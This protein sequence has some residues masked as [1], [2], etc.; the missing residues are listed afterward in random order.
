MNYRNAKRLENGWIDCEI[1][2]D[3]F[4]WIPFTCDPND[5]EP[6]FDVAA[7]HATM[8]ADP[9]TADYVP[10]TQEELDA[11]AALMRE[12][13]NLSFAQLIIGLVSE[14]W[15][16]E[17]DGRLW[18]TGTLPPQVISTIS[19]IPAEQRFAATAKATR[20]SVVNRLDP[21]VQMMALAQGRSDAELDD[22]F[23]AY[24]SV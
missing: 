3:K 13:M 4:G 2:H 6:L 12:G 16:T 21:L 5:T 15:I 14:Q 19:L 10:P 22:F 9:A 20:P 7:L 23:R 18:L 8:D 17:E 1:E 11:I 24:A